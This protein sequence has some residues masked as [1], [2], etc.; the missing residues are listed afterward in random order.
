VN[1]SPLVRKILLGAAESSLDIAGTALLPGA[2][3]ILKGAL[4]PVLERLKQRLGG[5][6]V[7]SSPDLARK[8]AAAFEADQHL[9]EI[10]RSALVEQLGDLIQRQNKIDADVQKLMLIVSGDEKL[11]QDIAGGVH[12]IEELIET[13]VN[14][15]DEAVDKLT[16]A[17]SRQAENSRSVRAIA[18]RAT[19]PVADLLE[20]QLQR[21]QVRAV[22]LVQEGAA[23]RALDE[24]REGLQLVALL[25][26]E[27]PTDLTARLQL[28]F[29]YKTYAQVADEI[30]RADEAAAFI[31]EAD[32]IFSY[33]LNDV[34]VDDKTAWDL[35]TAIHGQGNVLQA[36]GQFEAAISRYE[37][38]LKVMPGHPYALHDI[39]VAYCE[40]A[41]QG[42]PNLKE[43][44]KALEGLKATGTEGMPGLSR[45][46]IA[47]L[48]TAMQELERNAAGNQSAD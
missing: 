12:R 30:G 26:N 19:G 27:A 43:M 35:A 4:G 37:D 10:L 17:V 47:D 1:L 13:G 32:K 44:R 21:L 8:A 7:T 42:K 39:F 46:H 24:L 2:W 40:L 15:S 18:L 3:P 14:L 31:D 5:Q 38:A 41:R 36:R 34:A 25:L 22:E 20:R 11:L 45:Q 9:Q 33:V 23:D 48:E 28:G 6:D 29:I 16:T